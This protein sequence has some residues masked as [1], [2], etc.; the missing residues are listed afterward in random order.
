M[1]T[2]LEKLKDRCAPRS[3]EYALRREKQ[4]MPTTTNNNNNNNNKT[5]FRR[6][7]PWPFQAVVR[8]FLDVS[9]SVQQTNTV[10]QAITN[11]LCH[12]LM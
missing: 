3:R 1:D 11:M 10:V 9:L 6:C 5:S 2:Y 8:D 12:L 4:I 7:R